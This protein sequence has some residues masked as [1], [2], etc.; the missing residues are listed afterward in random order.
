MLRILFSS[1]VAVTLLASTLGPLLS[2]YRMA[3]AGFVLILVA[4]GAC[5]LAV[6]LGLVVS[7]MTK[8]Q[9]RERYERAYPN[10]DAL[11]QHLDSA[12]IRAVRD[13]NGLVHAIRALRKQVPD[14]PIADARAVVESL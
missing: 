8:R 13:S 14:V 7:S 9:R 5:W 10:R 3:D 11:V 1:A 2:Y 6:P 4:L 12:A